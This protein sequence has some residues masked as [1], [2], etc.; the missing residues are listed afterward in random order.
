MAGDG[1]GGG[2]G[3][4]GLDDMDDDDDEVGGGGGGSGGSGG[5]GR[6]GDVRPRKVRKGYGKILY[7]TAILTSLCDEGDAEIGEHVEACREEAGVNGKLAEGTAPTAPRAPT[8]TTTIPIMYE[9]LADGLCDKPGDDVLEIASGVYFKRSLLKSSLL[10]SAK[11][12]SLRYYF[13]LSY[14]FNPVNIGVKLG[15]TTVR[16]GD[17]AYVVKSFDHGDYTLGGRAETI[18]QWELLA[19]CDGG[20]TL[21]H[22]QRRFIL[23]LVEKYAIMMASVVPWVNGKGNVTAG[24]LWNVGDARK[25]A[26]SHKDKI[27]PDSGGMTL[28]ELTVRKDRHDSLHRRVL[29]IFTSL[30][31]AETLPAE[32]WGDQPDETLREFAKTT[33]SVRKLNCL[34]E[35]GCEKNDNIADGYLFSEDVVR[36]GKFVGPVAKRVGGSWEAKLKSVSGLLTCAYRLARPVNLLE[37]YQPLSSVECGILED[38]HRYWSANIG[39]VLKDLNVRDERS[40]DALDSE[41]VGEKAWALRFAQ[42]R[43]NFFLKH[44]PPVMVLGCGIRDID[45]YEMIGLHSMDSQYF[46]HARAGPGIL[47]LLLGT[48]SSAAAVQRILGT[49]EAFFAKA[50]RN[51]DHVNAK[52]NGGVGPSAK[53]RKQRVVMVEDKP[54]TREKK[55]RVFMKAMYMNGC[56]R[57]MEAIERIDPGI[58]DFCLEKLAGAQSTS[59][60]YDLKAIVGEGHLFGDAEGEQRVEN[61]LDALEEEEEEFTPRDFVIFSVALALACLFNGACLRPQDFFGLIGRTTFYIPSQERMMIR[62]PPEGKQTAT[63]EQNQ[64]TVCMEHGVNG[65]E[66][67]RWWAVMALVGRPFLRRANGGQ[68]DTLWGPLGMD[69]KAISQGVFGTILEGIGSSFFGLENVDVNAFRTAQDTLAVEHLIEEGFT[70][71]ANCIGELAR[72]QRTSRTVRRLQV[73]TVFL[74]SIAQNLERGV[75]V[76]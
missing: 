70:T 66:V 14:M 6:G 68:L 4:A 5:R 23:H 31:L 11:P 47:E 9:L 32:F 34:G 44:L 50:R 13:D 69:G 71:D 26:L 55:V 60:T 41:T 46:I 24:M 75:R 1:G 35:L 36:G 27:D 72:E 53:R 20:V 40:A 52:T 33:G 10:K 63:A 74:A 2:G 25:R 30:P 76:F 67:V 58:V 43:C 61:L 22:E 37:A 18:K 12:G 45:E 51:R 21:E 29:T 48:D 54:P 3:D 57:V 73:I 39:D 38:S 56:Q 7:S 15:V 8:G 64:S 59:Q 49:V 62:L 65:H 19:R 42:D 16:I 17:K 28:D